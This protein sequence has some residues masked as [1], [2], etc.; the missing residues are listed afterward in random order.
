MFLDLD[1][2]KAVNDCQGHRAGD[3]LLL[4][5][6]NRLQATGRTGRPWP[7]CPAMSLP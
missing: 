1:D 2:F 3:E 5:L 7:G 6:A 4:A